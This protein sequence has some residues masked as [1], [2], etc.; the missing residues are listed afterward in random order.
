MNKISEK[1]SNSREMHKMKMKA[2]KFQR[3]SSE[4]SEKKNEKVLKLQRKT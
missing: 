2:L 3:K 1:T 4:I